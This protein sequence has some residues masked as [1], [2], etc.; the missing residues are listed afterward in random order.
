MKTKSVWLITQKDYFK[1]VVDLSDH[2][3]RFIENEDKER[4]VYFSKGLFQNDVD[5]SIHPLHYALIGC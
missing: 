1:I 4:L 2:R 5:L 3:E